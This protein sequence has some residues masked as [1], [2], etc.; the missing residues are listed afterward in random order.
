MKPPRI[1]FYGNFGSGNLGNE[2]TLQTVIEHTLLRWPD[3]QLQCICA[4]PE[5][6]QSRHQISA[7]R[8]VARDSGWSPAA[9]LASEASPSTK[10]SGTHG[11]LR[12]L[13]RILRI[14][15]RRI[16]LE[17]GHWV[18][19][20]RI[21]SRS[22]LLIVPGTGIVT[23]GVCG[24]LGWPYDLF[25]LS[26]LAALCR[27][28]MVFLSVGVGPIQHQLGRWL[29]KRSLGLAQ[30]RS[31][32]DEAS[33]LY[34]Q[35]IGFNADR[36]PVYPDLVFGLSRRQLT[37]DRAPA[38]GR[39]I[40]GLGLKD[41]SGATDRA[42]TSHYRDYLDAMATFV[43][44]LREHHYSVRLLIGDL[45]YDTGV[46]QDLIGLLESRSTPAELP[47]VL[48]D[49]VPTVGELLHQLQGTDVVISPRL[50]NLVLALMLNKPVIALSDLPKVDSLL[51]G[52]GLA[53]YCMPLENLDSG[54]LISRFGQLQSDAARLKAHIAE[55]VDEYREALDEQYTSVFAV[56]W[57]RTKAVTR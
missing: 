53:Q 13:S 5:D 38:A 2:C 48:A 24:P 41:Y 52:F 7:F 28:K 6:V 21:L 40:V 57:G 10:V 12:P 54:S 46:R 25:K 27:V 14:A 43:L 42:G 32:R 15:L 22:D 23:D 33:K 1:A 26:V 29:I 19:S 9:V 4:V 37:L 50:H 49:P 36:D 3:A 30:Y 47:L 39:P 55:K 56:G 51:A 35:R 17:L 45:Q 20:L 18:K 8:S 11:P 31:Y 16:P 44:W 34:M